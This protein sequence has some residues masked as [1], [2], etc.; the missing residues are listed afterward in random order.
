MRSVSVWIPSLAGLMLTSGCGDRVRGDGFVIAGAPA[1]SFIRGVPCGDVN[2]DGFDDVLVSASPSSRGGYLIFG[3]DDEAP[4]DL[5]A[6]AEEGA[7]GRVIEPGLPDASSFS[8]AALGDLNGDGFVDLAMTSNTDETGVIHV[9][10]GGPA[11][12]NPVRPAELASGAGGFTLEA[13]LD[14]PHASPHVHGVGDVNGDGFA[15][16][17]LGFYS[18]G[19]PRSYH[20]VV[21]GGPAP[22]EPTWAALDAGV[23]GF[24]I[25]VGAAVRLGD[26]NGDGFDDVA[27]YDTGSY[28]GG[29]GVDIT[30]GGPA[31]ALAPYAERGSV[32]FDTCARPSPDPAGDI[33]GDGLADLVFAEYDGSRAYVLFGSEALGREPLYLRYPGQGLGDRGF[34]I[35]I[36][37]PAQGPNDLLYSPL[38]IVAA[39]DR[40]GDGCDD[41]YLRS[42]YGAEG[43]WLVFGKADTAPL[44]LAD[45]GLRLDELHLGAH[46][47]AGSISGVGAIRGRGPDD[48]VIS[49]PGADRLRAENSGRV[50]VLFDPPDL[51]GAD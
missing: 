41:L 35:E 42:L 5:A 6:V 25:G 28:C 12:A 48:L 20:Y 8:V 44:V 51:D 36:G 3:K 1:E 38:P 46:L 31:P 43:S 33:N 26:I 29:A 10:Y 21:F 27:T 19:A 50:F 39:G 37:E 17:A 34:V 18:Y 7:G 16:V 45:A 4:V 2:G 22:L 13:P 24:R 30:L 32:R 11:L 23:G 9:V 40:D 15:D 47:D 14:E 49:A